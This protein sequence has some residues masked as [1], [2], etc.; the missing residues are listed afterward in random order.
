[1][2]ASQ[3]WTRRPEGSTWGDFGP[4]DELG[5]LNLV[6][7]RKVLQGIA[8]VRHGITFCLSLPLDY[9]GG[10]VLNPRRA[11]PELRPTMRNG[12]PNMTYP[13]RCD[14]PTA[15]DVICDDQVVLTLQ[16]ST[17][18]DSLAHVG[19]MFDADGDGV[20]EPVF[21]NGYRAGEHIVGPVDYRGGAAIKRGEHVGATALS[22][23]NMAAHGVQGR[24]VMIDLE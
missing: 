16:Y 19:Q 17:Q 20:P 8:E 6:T 2:A 10:S 7:P 3:R 23:A 24:G 5:R 14:D 13:L 18:W 9:P 1:M 21:Y 12:R 11:P 15:L 4:D 22:I